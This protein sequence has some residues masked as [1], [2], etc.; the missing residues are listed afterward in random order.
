MI[1]SHPYKVY[2]SHT[3][4]GGI[5]YHANHLTF[6]EHCRRDWLTSLGFDSYFLDDG[7]HF[8][9]KNV[10]L[11]YKEALL[12]DETL[13]VSIDTV[14]AKNATLILT[15]SIYKNQKDLEQ[16]KAAAAAVITLTCVRHENG[17]IRPCR[18]DDALCLK[19][20]LTKP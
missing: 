9:V 20:G 7:R 17:R 3:D 8:V 19:L 1:F 6:F 5:V 13:I 4:A 10:T 15:Q 11:D 12:L 16:K 2:I 14:L 18:I